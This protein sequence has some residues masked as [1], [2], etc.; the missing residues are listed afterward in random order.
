MQSIKKIHGKW[1]WEVTGK[2]QT[3]QQIPINDQLLQAIVRYRQFYALSPLPHADDDQPLIMNL[4]D[5]R[6]ISS[7]MIHRIVKQVFNACADHIK[8]DYPD[9]AVKLRKA[10]THWIRHTAIT[11]QADTGIDLRYI[12]RN[13]RHAS[14]ETTMLYQ[15]AETDRWHDS[16]TQ[17]KMPE[18]LLPAK[19][20]LN[21]SDP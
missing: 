20:E 17:H 13:A 5:T 11:H 19:E 10:S 21:D 4:M 12:Q 16:M 18:T 15:H 3:T 6:G 8:D 9:Y 7:N 14:I 2:G 1:W